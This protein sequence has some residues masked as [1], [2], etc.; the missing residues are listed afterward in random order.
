MTHLFGGVLSEENLARLFPE[1]GFLPAQLSSHPSGFD[2]EA[3]W[4]SEW[5]DLGGEG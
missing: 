4:E 3:D 2:D 5:I 1:A